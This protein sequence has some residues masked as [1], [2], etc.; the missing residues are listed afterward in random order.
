MLISAI[1]RNLTCKNNYRN[2]TNPNT[3]ANNKS[4]N[5]NALTQD[6]FS[7]SSVSTNPASAISFEAAGIKFDPKVCDLIVPNNKMIPIKPRFKSLVGAIQDVKIYSSDHLKLAAWYL[8]PA[9][10]KKPVFLFLN[11]T[12]SNRTHQQ[13]VAKFFQDEGYGALMMDYREFGGN[14]GKATEKGLYEDASAGLNHLTN[15]LGIKD[16]RI[17]VWG[18]SMGGAVGI[19]TVRTAEKEGREISWIL[20]SSFTN[21]KRIKKHFFKKDIGPIKDIPHDVR[22]DFIRQMEADETHIKFNTE[23]RIAKLNSR[24]RIVH[25]A[26]DGTI[27]SIMAEKNAEVAKNADLKIEHAKA[28]TLLTHMDRSWTFKHV[29]EF[30][31]A[32]INCV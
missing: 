20:D 30:V 1:N 28:V 5:L 21:E 2:N 10:K 22:K 27:P 15:V 24:G 31:E 13:S 23:K 29:K 17:I 6:S 7:R 8:P 14:A 9:D 18:Y 12:D 19:K 32:N 4:P 26:G 11:G 16:N 25:N 3:A